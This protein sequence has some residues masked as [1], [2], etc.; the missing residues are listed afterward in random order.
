MLAMRA[1]S[2]LDAHLEARLRELLL[3][4]A[5]AFAEAQHQRH[6]RVQVLPEAVGHR[7]AAECPAKVLYMMQMRSAAC[8]S[9]RCDHEDDNRLNKSHWQQA[10]SPR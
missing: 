7:P 1:C 9:V 4:V 6:R 8:P 2:M 10:T 3:A 5:G